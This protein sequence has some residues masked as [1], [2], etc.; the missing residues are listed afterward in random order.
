[1]L[2]IVFSWDDFYAKEKSNFE[3]NPEDTGECWFDDSDAEAKMIQ[4]LSDKIGELEAIS[5][6]SR[7]CDLGTGNGHLLFELRNEGFEGPL[8][9]VD[10]SERSVEFATKVATAEDFE[11]VTFSQCDILSPD[12]PFFEEIRAS[13]GEFDILLDKGTLDAIALSEDLYENN[14]KRG[15]LVYPKCVAPLLKK[16]G[17]ALITSCN[18]TTE[19]L[20]SI[21][22]TDGL[23]EV[24]DKVN[25]PT[26]QFGGIQGSTV[27]TIAFL[28][29]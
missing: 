9:G 23:Y 14:T 26:F 6:S 1:M 17:I 16:G 7:I 3:S 18:F 8:V 12:H 19:E 24:W 28:K 22:T 2:T 27:C 4:F 21:M 25:Y 11:N 5:D 10:Y 20:I 13:S 15:H 29:I